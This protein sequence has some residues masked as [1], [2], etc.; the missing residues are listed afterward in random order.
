MP[1]VSDFRCAGCVDDVVRVVLCAEH[2]SAAFWH[3]C[4]HPGYLGSRDVPANGAGRHR[5][6][7][8][9]DGVQRAVQNHQVRTSSLAQLYSDGK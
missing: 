4:D 8:H 5:R 1:A 2:G 7:E 3:D 9:A 6:Q